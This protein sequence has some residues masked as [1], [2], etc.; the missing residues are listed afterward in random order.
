MLARK[1]RR[2]SCNKRIVKIPVFFMVKIKRTRNKKG[3][4]CCN[5]YLDVYGLRTISET[6]SFPYPQWLGIPCNF[7]QLS[8]SPD[9][10]GESF[11]LPAWK[12]LLIN[13]LDQ[14]SPAAGWSYE[15]GKWLEDDGFSFT[16]LQQHSWRFISVSLLLIE[17]CVVLPC[18]LLRVD[19][20]E[21][22]WNQG[23]RC[24]LS[25]E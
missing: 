12:A 3:R 23:S 7:L 19:D 2:V 9:R 5:R 13:R 15:R 11:F 8:I 10:T 14:P 17:P 25:G 16:L 21:V 4:S 20:A 24:F 18:I 22:S 6:D 1:C